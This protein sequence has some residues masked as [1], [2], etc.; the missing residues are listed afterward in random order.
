MRRGSPELTLIMCDRKQPRWFV[1]HVAGKVNHDT[2]HEEFMTGAAGAES[3]GAVGGV[4][5]C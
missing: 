2:E 5:H 4:Q 1:A 3:R